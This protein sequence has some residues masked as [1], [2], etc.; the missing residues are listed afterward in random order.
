MLYR[1]SGLIKDAIDQ[2]VK[3]GQ[4]KVDAKLAAA[5]EYSIEAAI[6]KV[7][8]SEAGDFV[9]DEAVQIHGGMGFSEEMSVARGYRD[10]RINRIFEGTNEINR[11]LAVGTIFKKAMK[12]ELDIMGP[13]MAVQKELMAIPDFGAAQDQH[14]FAAEFKAIAQAKKAILMAAGAAAQKYMQELD[15]QQEVM[16]NLADMAIDVYTAEST[17]L[18]VAKMVAKNGEESSVLY[19]DIAKTYLSD[20]MERINLSGKH[21][22]VAFAEGDMLTMM[23]MGLKRFTKYEAFNTTKARRNVAAKLIAD[24]AYSL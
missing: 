6:L 19:I 17:L 1:V 15:K 2:G 7:V 11:L 18:R 16:M 23:L 8:G 13:A 12:G 21:A 3:A 9:I 14:F 5:D 4:S 24:N 20:A 10:S 22:I